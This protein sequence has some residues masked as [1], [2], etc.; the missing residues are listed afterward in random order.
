M[1]LINSLRF[2]RMLAEH[3]PMPHLQDPKDIV[4]GACIYN[5]GVWLPCLHEQE[6][7]AC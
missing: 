5:T 6:L 7:S 3:L 1:H 2:S 4:A